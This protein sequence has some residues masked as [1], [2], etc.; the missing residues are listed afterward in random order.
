M[1]FNPS[2]LFSHYFLHISKITANTSLPQQPRLRR[3]TLLRPHQAPTPRHRPHL[4]TQPQNSTLYSVVGPT[5]LP[6][7]N[8]D[9]DLTDLLI[10]RAVSG[11]SGSLHT[12]VKLDTATSKAIND[13][14]M[15]VIERLGR[16]QQVLCI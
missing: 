1:H 16:L 13:L 7:Y 3:L 11:S 10:D 6:S 5:L 4:N 2:P 15:E 8:Q 14:K 12:L 9:H